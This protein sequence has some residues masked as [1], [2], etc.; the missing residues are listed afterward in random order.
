MPGGRPAGYDYV[1]GYKSTM[2]YLYQL[3]SSVFGFTTTPS[4][5]LPV[6][7]WPKRCFEGATCAPGEYM[8]A[9]DWENLIFSSGQVGRAIG[10]VTPEEPDTHEISAKE[11]ADLAADSNNGVGGFR[12][13]DT[14]DKP[15]GILTA[16][17][18]NEL[19]AEISNLGK[20]SHQFTLEARYL[21][22]HFVKEYQVDGIDKNEGKLPIDIPITGVADFKERALPIQF[23]LFNAE[24][25]QQYSQELRVPVLDF[26]EEEIREVLDQL[27]DD[28]STALK[29]LA[30]QKMKPV[31][32]QTKP[33]TSTTP[34]A[35]VPSTLPTKPSIPGRLGTKK[36]TPVTSAEKP[37]GAVSTSAAPRTVAL[38]PK[39]ELPTPS[40]TQPSEATEQP[41]N[42]PTSPVDARSIT[43]GVILSVV[44]VL[45]AGLGWVNA[46]GLPKLPF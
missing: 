39:P 34:T 22:Q 43:I 17:Y 44:G 29:N 33:P 12:L 38:A 3:D 5:S 31:L 11:L 8:I 26:T 42:N 46:H 27:P 6:S 15:N 16:S 10:E 40:T 37:T 30:D 32:T 9:P 41:D 45:L 14:E 24:G 23:T 21:D 2:N 35:T 19:H 13:L 18:N 28:S 7:E 1:P 25:E 4:Y 36:A 20:D